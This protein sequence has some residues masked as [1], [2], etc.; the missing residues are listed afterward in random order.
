MDPG[1]AEC[2]DTHTRRA[3]A[4]NCLLIRMPARFAVHWRAAAQNGLVGFLARVIWQESGFNTCG[5]QNGRPWT[6]RLM[7]ANLAVFLPKAM[8][9]REISG[10]FLCDRRTVGGMI[11]IL[12]AQPKSSYEGRAIY[13]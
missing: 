13:R 3:F 5:A 12:S 11:T 2:S 1:I 9:H 8:S 6:L 10:I 7:S 4:F